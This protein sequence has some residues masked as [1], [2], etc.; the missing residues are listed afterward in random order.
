MRIVFWRKATIYIT[1][2]SFY[3]T[4]TELSSEVIETDHIIL[5]AK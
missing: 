4:L 5:N 2:Y 1:L 3:F